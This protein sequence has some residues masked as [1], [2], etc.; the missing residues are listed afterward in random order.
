M[1]EPTDE[2]YAA[3][4]DG[5]VEQAQKLDRC[6]QRVLEE[7]RAQ[8]EDTDGVRIIVSH[9]T[10]NGAYTATE[11]MRPSWMD[12]MDKPQQPPTVEDD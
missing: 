12:K 1:S 7:L 9:R 3:H 8:G 4:V 11:L 10:D 6:K 5:I 2:E